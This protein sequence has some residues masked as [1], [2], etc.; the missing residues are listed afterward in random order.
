MSKL[1]EIQLATNLP[2]N[3]PETKDIIITM[4]SKNSS[5]NQ[6]NKVCLNKM[7]NYFDFTCSFLLGGI[8]TCQKTWRDHETYFNSE[9]SKS[10]QYWKNN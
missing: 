10:K 8:N 9:K 1:E 5:K 2:A 3:S 4:P 6:K 7:F